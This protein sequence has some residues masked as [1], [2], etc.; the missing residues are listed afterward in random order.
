MTTMT[1]RRGGVGV[2]GGEPPGEISF[3]EPG[4]SG[5]ETGAA[6]L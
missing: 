2:S 3:A 4:N 6:G 1:R 5:N